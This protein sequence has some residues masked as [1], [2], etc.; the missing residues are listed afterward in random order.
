[1]WRT[2]HICTN[3]LL[4]IAVIFTGTMWFSEDLLC[5]CMCVS[6][7]FSIETH[8]PPW[9]TDR[10]T[11]VHFIFCK[12]CNRVSVPYIVLYFDF[13]HSRPNGIRWWFYVHI[14]LKITIN[15]IILSILGWSV[16]CLRELCFFLLLCYLRVS[17]F[18]FVLS[19]LV[20]LFHFVHFKNVLLYRKPLRFF[21]IYSHSIYVH[22][23]K[24]YKKCR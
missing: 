4:T 13:K 8:K 11:H 2:K 17:L 1:M 24:N 22:A 21:S 3:I 20:S 14:R 16:F 15:A 23:R 10:W 5:V 12:N 19:L 7:Y 6:M 9:S 18:V